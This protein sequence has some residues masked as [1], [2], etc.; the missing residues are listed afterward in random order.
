MY[1][2]V[3]SHTRPT[4]PSTPKNLSHL[5]RNSERPTSTHPRPRIP[6]WTASRTRRATKAAL[7]LRQLIV[8]PP[9][10]QRSPPAANHRTSPSKTTVPRLRD[11][12]VDRLRTQLLKPV[13]A[14]LVIHEARALSG[15]GD[16][17]RAVCLDCGEVR[18]EEL[19]RGAE[20]EVTAGMKEE[21]KSSQLPLLVSLLDPS[22]GT[23]I[24]CLP[25]GLLL[26]AS[27]MSLRQPLAG[28]LPS[29]DTLKRGFDAL[30][31]AES[32]I[33]LSEGPN[34]AGIHPPTDRLSIYTC[35][36]AR[37]S[38]IRHPHRGDWPVLSLFQIGGVSRS[39]S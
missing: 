2:S 1:H 22:D 9:S 33:Y 19:I 39:R 25:F 20:E 4:L 7:A 37:V 32:K 30:L 10:T 28:A 29:A 34:H 27:A 15:G 14:G 36:W 38:S 3:P 16:P 8:D 17:T 13:E 24:S 11:K 5:S 18:A 21:A 12:D 35:E 26:P 23:D 6:S 31:T